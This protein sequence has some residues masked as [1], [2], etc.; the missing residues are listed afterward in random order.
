MDKSDIPDESTNVEE[1]MRNIKEN[2]KTR[3]AIG[4]CANAGDTAGGK[5]DESEEHAPFEIGKPEEWDYV[6]SNRDIQN[7]NYFISS[8]RRILGKVLVKGRELVHGE[9]RRYVDPM[10][11]KQKEFNASIVRILNDIAVRLGGISAQIDGKIAQSQSTISAQVDDKITQSQSTISAQIDGKIA[12]SESKISSEI[13]EQVKSVIAA[14][15]EDIENRAW[16]AEI[17][18]GRIAKESV[19]ASNTISES[20]ADYINYFVFEERFRGTRADIKERQSAFIKYFKGCRNVLD[21]GC[22]RGEFQELLRD[23]EIGGHGIDIDED[24][25]N[26]CKSKGL[27][28]EK[29]DAVSYLQKLED[30]SLDGIFIDQVVEHLEQEYLIKM[31]NLSFMKLIYGGTIVVETVNPLSFFSFANFYIDMSHKRPVHPE[32]LRFLLNAAGFREIKIELIAP[33]RDDARLKKIKIGER[34]DGH[35]EEIEIYNHN[36]DML[37]AIIYGPQDYA[38]IG[39]K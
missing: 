15:N 13:G 18:D 22:G 29:I 14:M 36:I 34:R 6:N 12:Q 10:V 38:L 32:T 11:W 20:H 28:V 7:D 37:N 8:H 24:M 27:D 39:I 17:L 33:V 9:V 4:V 23:Y 26:F 30:K 1:I 19:R 31:L 25:V 2:I 3:R 21:I 35:R 16:L 5:A